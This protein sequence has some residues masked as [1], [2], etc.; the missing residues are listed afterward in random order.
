MQEAKRQIALANSEFKAASA[1]MDSWSKSSDGLKAKLKQ[2]DS[3][4]NS[5]KSILDSLKKQYELTANEM[6][7][8]SAQAEKL[9]IAINNQQAVVNKTEKEIRNYEGALDKV[10]KAEE[11]AAKTGKDVDTVLE[12]MDKDLKDT[13]ESAKKSGDG[14]TVLKG[15]IANLAST[16]ITEAISGL[17][18]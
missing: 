7:E 16:A 6:G 18:N 4:L 13:G 17:K 11:I 14:F 3:N 12:D 15:V 10:S 9:K 2:L 8:D 1:G 5:Q